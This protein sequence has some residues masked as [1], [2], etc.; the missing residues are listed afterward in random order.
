M[1]FTSKYPSRAIPNLTVYEYLFENNP[2]IKDQT[3][4]FVDSDDPSQAITY[5]ELKNMILKL[6]AGLKK[7]FPDF[8]QGDVVALYSPNNIYYPP[9]LHGISAA[10]VAAIDNSCDVNTAASCLETVQAKVIVA[11]PDTLSRAQEAAKAVGIPTENILVF[12]DTAN[13]VFWNHQDVITPVKYTE[14]QLN[15]LPCFLY[16]TSGT[17]GKKKAVIITHRMMVASSEGVVNLD[18]N[19]AQLCHMELHHSS[20]L[21]G[22]LNTCIR[23]GY[24]TY[25]LKKFNFDVYFAAIERYRVDFVSIQPWIISHMVKEKSLTKEYDLSS[26]NVAISSGSTSSKELCCDFFEI[27]KCPILNMYGMTEVLGAFRGSSEISMKGSV[28]V[29]APGFEVKLLDSDGKELGYNELG[30]MYIKGPTVTYGYYNNKEATLKSFDNEGFFRTQDLVR[31]SEEGCFTIVDRLT[32][33]WKYKY[34]NVTPHEI[35]T[36]LKTHPSVVECSAVGIFNKYDSSWEARVFVSLLKDTKDIE[37][38]KREILEIGKTK[39]LEHQQISGGLYVMDSLPKNTSGK[40]DRLALR[41]Y[42]VAA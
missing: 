17:T 21:A 36:V 5:A 13:E 15:R 27:F 16:F 40:V 12:G 37:Q 25:I 35:E 18:P 32:D 23:L 34:Y 3:K 38:V 20:A 33:I 39:L 2:N 14:E 41:Q 19:L 30:E 8:K 42:E 4:S 1:L 29:I 6:G 28:G 9:T 11:H 26:L 31:V 24:T 7:K 10:V 22:A